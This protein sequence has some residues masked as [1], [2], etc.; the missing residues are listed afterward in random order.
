[1]TAFGRYAR[2]YDA[3]YAD[4]AYA[5]ECDVIEAVVGCRRSPPWRVLDVGCGTGTHAVE[6]ARRGHRVTGVDRSDDMLDAARAKAAGTVRFLHGDARSLDLGETFDVVTCLFA[7]LSYQLTADDALAAL[8][9]F[10]RHLDPGGVLVCDYW[11]GP[12]VLTVGPA[13]KVKEVRDG[14]RCIVRTAIPLG[15]DRGAQTNATR[16]TVCVVGADGD[17]ADIVEETHTVRFFLP[18]EVEAY[19]RSARFEVLETFA[20]WRRDAVLHNRAWTAVMVARAV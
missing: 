1:M 16:Y 10:R 17:I 9:A 14:D 7:V 19:A 13:V 3:I 5:E 20:D 6:L 11:H 18:G 2:Y 12:A 15:V 4:K 8:R